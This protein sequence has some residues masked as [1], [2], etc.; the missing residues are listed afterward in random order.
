MEKRKIG[1]IT[2]DN[3]NNYGN[4]LQNYALQKTINRIGYD[5]ETIGMQLNSHCLRKMIA[6]KILVKKILGMS[7]NRALQ[8]RI[9]AFDRFKKEKLIFSTYR[10]GP[11][12]FQSARL[13]NYKYVVFGSDQIWN[14]KFSFVRDYFDFF[15][16]TFMP[17]EKKVAYAASFGTTSVP[18]E[19]EQKVTK[20]LNEFHSISVRESA[21]KE[22]VQQLTSR[23]CK[24]VADPTMLLTQEQWI[25]LERPCDALVGKKFLLTYFLGE[26]SDQIRTQVRA[27]AK[28]HCLELVNL[29]NSLGSCK[30]KKD[31]HYFAV[32]PDQFVWLI[33]NCTAMITDSYHGTVFSIIFAKPF[34]TISR[35]AN[36]NNNNMNSRIE[37]L[38]ERFQSLERF[39]D[40]NLDPILLRDAPDSEKIVLIQNGL[41][42]EGINYLKQELS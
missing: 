37:T 33:H 40:S 20:A 7:D 25:Q 38:L 41:A 36:E 24:V 3:G 35:I 10:V 28:E 22:I 8:K 23:T 5:V 30:E 18:A 34:Q 26:V 42:L 27:Y 21:G 32:A 6:I 12:K 4:Q 13:N 19:F 1:I 15:F 11:K 29:N 17:K 39:A 9:F 31:L 2:I 16:G 14:L